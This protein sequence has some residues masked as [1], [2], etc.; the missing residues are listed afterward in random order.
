MQ[1][2]NDTRLWSLCD[3]LEHALSDLLRPLFPHSLAR[4]RADG[5]VV[6]PDAGTSSNDTYKSVRV[7]F[8]ELAVLL[9]RDDYAAADH[10]PDLYRLVE[11][12]RSNATLVD[13]DSTKDTPSRFRLA[14]LFGTQHIPDSTS[15]LGAARDVAS[16]ANG[17]V[18]CTGGETTNGKIDDGH[19]GSNLNH[20]NQATNLVLDG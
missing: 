18:I 7:L 20:A 4:A 12:D 2:R 11:E 1:A 10:L 8:V 5:L 3:S 16:L 9:S 6:V 13:L 14:L 17:R 19:V 15:I